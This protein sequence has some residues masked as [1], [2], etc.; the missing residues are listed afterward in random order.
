[1]DR[2]TADRNCGV[3]SSARATLTGASAEWG[4]TLKRDTLTSARFYENR[5]ALVL[6]A[7]LARKIA[8]WTRISIAEIPAANSAVVFSLLE[9]LGRVTQF[10]AFRFGQ[11]GFAGN[12]NL[13]EQFVDT[14]RKL[15][16]AGR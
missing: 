13:G 15:L 10:F 4:I 3:S 9:R 14:G 16:N 6:A 12:G 5:A 8:F 2:K 1:M 11:T 7:L